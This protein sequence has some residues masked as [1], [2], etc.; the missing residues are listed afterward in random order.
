MD[1]NFADDLSA[2]QADQLVRETV[3]NFNSYLNRWPDPRTVDAAVVE[4]FGEGHERSLDLI[5]DARFS[6]THHGSG[7][8]PTVMIWNVLGTIGAR[9]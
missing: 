8:L 7:Y 2:E 4:W 1:F 6:D 5:Y 3:E 9:A